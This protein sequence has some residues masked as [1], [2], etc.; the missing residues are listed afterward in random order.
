M[1]LRPSKAA[2]AIGRAVQ[3]VVASLTISKVSDLDFGT[4]PQG[5]I[6]KTV[7]PGAAENAEN[8]SF[9]V[10]GNANAVYNITLPADGTIKMVTA[11]GGAPDKEI[12]VDGF[13]SFPAASGTLDVAGKQLLLVGATRAA[14]L[15]NQ[16]P[17]NYAGDFTVTVAY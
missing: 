7:A 12:S 15:A 13:A 10:V 17:G 8:A 2:S 3:V 11:G 9:D 14:L 4:A 5:D 16:T 1:A 6:A